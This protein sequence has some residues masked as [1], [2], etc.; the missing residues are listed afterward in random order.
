MDREESNVEGC[1]QLEFKM[2]HYLTNN[3]L[4]GGSGSFKLDLVTKE[5]LEIF[6]N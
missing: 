6:S 5:I 2:R 3:P 4:M 1:I